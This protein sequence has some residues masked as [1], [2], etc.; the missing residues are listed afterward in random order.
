[1]VRREIV[2]D[3]YAAGVAR[4]YLGPGPDS[5]YYEVFTDMDTESVNYVDPSDP[6]PHPPVLHCFNAWTWESLRAGLLEDL[7]RWGRAG[8][9]DVAELVDAILDHLSG[10]GGAGTG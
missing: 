4:F 1:M 7:A 2:S 8:D 6:T 5:P 3:H 10:R 9:P